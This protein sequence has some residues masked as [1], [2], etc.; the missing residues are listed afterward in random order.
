MKHRDATD[1]DVDSLIIFLFDN[2]E[3]GKVS[4]ILEAIEKCIR[5]HGFKK[6]IKNLKGRNRNQMIKDLLH[7]IEVLKERMTVEELKKGLG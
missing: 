4:E 5:V 2:N 7:I 3:T 1:V 6:V